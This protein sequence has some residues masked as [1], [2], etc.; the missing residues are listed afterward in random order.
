MVGVYR[1]EKTCF[2]LSM[3]D[4][5]DSAYTFGLEGTYNIE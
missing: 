4:A 2:E 3:N 1:N 5:G